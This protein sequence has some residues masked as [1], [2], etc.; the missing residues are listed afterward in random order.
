MF[1][2]IWGTTT[3]QERIG[4]VADLCPYCCHVRPFT[5]VDHFR[6]SHIYYIPLGRGQH[7]D[8]TRQCGGCRR[9]LTFDEQRYAQPVA[10][11]QAGT[12]GADQMLHYTNPA[13]QH[14]LEELGKLEQLA[15]AT[16]YRDHGADGRLLE[17]VQWVRWLS[18][19]GAQND[20][21]MHFLATWSAQSD[22]D[23]DA[24]LAQ[25][26]DAGHRVRAMLS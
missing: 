23:R 1:F 25:L 18:A 7:V 17:C 15:Q 2:I 16:A 21:A 8:R 5:V 12:M 24:L 9:H 14:R 3:R 26:R 20:G 6:V 19:A 11:A 4:V 13:L 10:V 22:D